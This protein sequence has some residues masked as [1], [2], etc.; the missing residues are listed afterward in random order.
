MNSSVILAFSNAFVDLK[1]TRVVLINLA[2]HHDN[3]VWNAS[4]MFLECDIILDGILDV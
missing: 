3:F 1:P 4:I 2:L